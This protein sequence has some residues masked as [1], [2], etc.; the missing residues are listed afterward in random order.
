MIFHSWPVV[1][2]QLLEKNVVNHVHFVANTLDTLW[3][4]HDTLLE[5]S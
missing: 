5:T 3:Y 1:A 2:D 4:L